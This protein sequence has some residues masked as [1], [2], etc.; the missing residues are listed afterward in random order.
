MGKGREIGLQLRDWLDRADRQPLQARLLQGWLLDALGEETR[1]AGPL[2][3]LAHQP[4]FLKLLQEPSSAVRRSLVEA[5]RQELQGIYAAPALLELADL[6]EAVSAQPGA[7]P[8]Q[9]SAESG[10]FPAEASPVAAAPAL[11]QEPVP[12]QTPDGQVPGQRL[13]ALGRSLR[14]LAPGLALGFAT[15]L[16]LAWLGGELAR[17]LPRF[18]NGLAVLLVL[19]A[20]PQLVLLRPPLRR[21][22]RRGALQLSQSTDPHWVWRW[23]TA[24]WV[25]QRQGEAML[26]GAMLLILLLGTPLPLGQLLLRQSEL[27]SDRS[28][29]G[30]DHEARIAA[31]HEVALVDEAHARAA[32]ER[33]G[34][35]REG[36]RGARI[37]AA[38]VW[39]HVDLASMMPTKL[40]PDFLAVAAESAGG[41]K[42]GARIM[43]RSRPNESDRRHPWPLRF[44]D[45][46]ALGHMNNAAYW[47]A[48]EEWL[49]AHRDVRAPFDAVLEHLAPI[50]VGHEVS[51]IVREDARH[52]A[53]WHE[54]ENTVVAA[55][56][57]R[58]KVS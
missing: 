41:R 3:D 5:L 29:F 14:P 4:L 49:G 32:V 13:Q 58:L 46:D 7:R 30:E 52:V 22:R 44:S 20:L 16:V 37:E 19:L 8:S 45:M 24:P 40:A 43:L 12:P 6:L 42:V 50:T 39:V 31:A 21:L 18:C 2:R 56:E 47:E 33:R 10:S 51:T 11:P 38:A 9:P 15:A 23:I 28:N 57:V 53:M 54:V 36:E 1:L 55:A 34:D 48:I 26:N 27:N 17:L 25:H 35:G